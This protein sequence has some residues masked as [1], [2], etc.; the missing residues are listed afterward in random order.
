MIEEGI[1]FEIM[2]FMKTVKEL[3]NNYE[4]LPMPIGYVEGIQTIKEL[5]NLKNNDSISQIEKTA[6]I[7]KIIMDFCRRFQTNS[8]FEINSI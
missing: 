5:A 7:R 8:R 4:V 3:G 2:D 6:T 1:L